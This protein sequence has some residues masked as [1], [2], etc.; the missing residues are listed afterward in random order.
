MI[1]VNQ[2]YSCAVVSG[3]L[4]CWDGSSLSADSVTEIIPS[5]VSQ[6]SSTKHLV[7]VKKPLNWLKTPGNFPPDEQRKAKLRKL[8]E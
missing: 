1:G 2:G 6:L 8:A 4:K 7:N 5:G 3:A